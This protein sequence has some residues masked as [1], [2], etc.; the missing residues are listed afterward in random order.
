MNNQLSTINPKITIHNGKAITTSFSVA[1]YFGKRHDNILRAIDNIDCSEKFTNLN[2]EVCFKNN[3]LQ[4][5]KPQKYYQMTKD[6]FVF[7]VMGFTGKK[8][9]QFK[10][11]YIAEFNRMEAELHSTPKYQPEAHE[12]FSS[13]DTQNLA[14]IIAHMT[15][16]FRFQN[17]WNNAIWYALRH[18]TGISSPNQFEVRYIPVIAAECERIWQVTQHLQELISEAEK[19]VIKRIIRKR[20]D[21]NFVLKQIED[22]LLKESSKS[23]LTD[24]LW[25]CHKAKLIDFERR[26]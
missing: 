14:R 17:S 16:D 9:A 11:A 8:A 25:K 12:K 10:E 13:N 3:E 20:E 2:F 23:P 18:V 26:T 4:N 19:T 21:A 7:L 5:G 15:Q 6:G 22:I 1:D 24:T